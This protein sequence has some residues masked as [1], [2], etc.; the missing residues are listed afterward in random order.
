[1]VEVLKDVS[2]EIAKGEVISIIGPSGTG[3][4]TFLRC[5]NH[6]ET[7]T[8]GE[9]I[10]DGHNILDKRANLKL[11]RR[12]MGMVFQNFNLF[13]CKTVLENVMIGPVKLLG[14]PKNE[15]EKEGLRLLQMVGVSGKANSYPSELSGGQKQRVAIARCLSMKPEI[16]LFD[17]PTSALDPTMVSEVLSVIRKLAKEGMTMAIVTHEMKFAYDVSTRIFFMCDGYIYEEGTPEQIFYHPQKPQ[18]QSFVN[19]LRSLQFDVDN[20]HYDVYGMHQEISVFCQ[21]YVIDR[22]QEYRME[23]I[24]E[25]L[26]INI[27]PFTGPIQ[28]VIEYS[29]VDYNLSLQIIQRNCTKEILDNPRNDQIS[30]KIIKGSSQLISENQH[31]EDRILTIHIRK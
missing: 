4:S 25:E 28:I 29:E 17:E 16:I 12:K 23:L 10:V 18:T 27:L 22:Q 1:M 26:L 11:L 2:C 15:A 6:L 30:V 31:G 24:L 14:M 13:E 20:R 5:I 19:R 8:S 21:K 7:A 3:K 9:I